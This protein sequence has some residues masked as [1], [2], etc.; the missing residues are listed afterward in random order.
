MNRA[1]AY[2]MGGLAAM[3]QYDPD[4][5]FAPP[6]S[7]FAQRFP[8]AN[9]T[10]PSPPPDRDASEA[11]AYRLARPYAKANLVRMGENPLPE[12]AESMA[13]K[14]PWQWGMMLAAPGSSLVGQGI[15]L[16][17]PT[18]RA[19]GAAAGFTLGL[20]GVSDKA[21]GASLKLPKKVGELFDYSRIRDVPD[22]KQFDLPRY[23]PPRGVSERVEDL[24]K[25]KRVQNQ[26]LD[27]IQKGKDINAET[28]YYNEPLRQAFIDELGKKEGPKGFQRYM[29]YVAATS[30]RSDVETNARNAS[31]YYMLEKQGLPVPPQGGVNPQPYGHMAQNL[32]R[33]NAEKIRSGEYFNVV[34]N[35]KPLSFSQNLQGNFAPVTVDAH[36][37]K[38]PAMLARDPNFIAGSIKL[39]KGQPTINP[40]KMLESGEITMKDALQRPVYWASK[41]NP[42]EYGAMEQYYKRLAAEAGMTPAQVQAAAWAGGGKLTGLESVAGDPFMRSVEN[43]AIKTAAERGISPAE[44]LSQ[45][46]RG[47]APLLGF[48]GAA[49]LGPG[50]MS[51]LATQDEYR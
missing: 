30:P 38:L 17:P 26:M 32:H 10:L 49:V 20:P 25:N 24:V 6:R 48:G 11:A 22:V 3:D 1:E 39:E 50:Y 5:D 29:D 23:D 41:P 28:F 7:T 27:Y 37:F 33:E 44:A 19:L 31:Y 34:N 9:W 51:G 12:Y 47:K 35:P 46:M 14:E 42:N 4:V 2:Q 15:R 21:E 8:E 45:M 36:A 18:A 16:I 43:R 40:S 13:P